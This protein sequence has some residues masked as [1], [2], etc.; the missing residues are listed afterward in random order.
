MIAPT[1]S[2]PFLDSCFNQLDATQN[3]RNN[4]FEPNELPSDTEDKKVVD[5]MMIEVQVPFAQGVI[6]PISDVDEG[7]GSNSKATNTHKVA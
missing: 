4:T 2:N 7:E 5:V 3:V 6:A 1:L